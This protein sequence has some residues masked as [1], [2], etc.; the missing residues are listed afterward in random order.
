MNQDSSI[1]LRAGTLA[2]A[3]PCGVICYEAFKSVCS[4]HGFPPDFPSADAATGLMSVL[5][6]HPGFHSVVAERDG[7]VVGSNFLDERS[8]ISGVG[9]ISVDPSVQNRGIG[10][11]LMQGVLDRAASRKAP[12][13]RLLQAAFHNRSLCLYSTLGFRTR[14]PVSIMQGA[15]L[16]Q[17]FAGYGVRPATTAD[18][19]DCTRLCRA[20]HGFDRGRELDDGVVQKTASV[21][22]HQG[23]ITGYTT[24][25]SFNGHSVAETNTGLMALIG[26]ATAFDGPGFL[27]PTRNHEAFTW[28]LKGGLR[29]VYQMTLMSIGLYNEPTG[30]YLPSVLY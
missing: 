29:L 17:A 24:G 7:R 10:A 13:V 28:C 27:L 14:E 8:I 1:K 30:A 21:V 19:A 22:E 12:G 2:D 16:K 20:V 11:K 4:S 26:A 25:V 5:L 23:R 9:P 6:A 15:P 3:D 18:L